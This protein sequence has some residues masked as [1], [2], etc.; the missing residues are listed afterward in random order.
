MVKRWRR[1]L[2]RMYLRWRIDYHAKE[3]DYYEA[4]GGSY[5]DFIRAL[6]D[7]DAACFDYQLLGGK[8]K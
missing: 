1:W 8:L 4:G 3:I 6:N 5:S 7:H 2:H